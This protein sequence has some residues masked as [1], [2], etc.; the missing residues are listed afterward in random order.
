MYFLAFVV[1]TRYSTRYLE[2]NRET[3]ENPID[4]DNRKETYGFPSQ[5]TPP[6]K[7]GVISPLIKP[8]RE[9]VA[10]LAGSIKYRPQKNS[11]FQKEL[12]KVVSSI[13]RNPNLLISSDK[14][15]NFYE[16]KPG[17]YEK[18]VRDN[19]TT[20]YSKCDDNEP[21][22]EV[23]RED[24]K[25]AKDLKIDDRVFVTQKREA[26][27]FLKDHKQNFRNNPKCRVINPTKQELGKVSKQ[28]L[29]KVQ[30]VSVKVT[31][32]PSMSQGLNLI[33]YW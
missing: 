29:E 2:E 30:G 19:V 18:M 3:N 23:N 31:F 17:D 13:E 1:N 9:A 27:I 15:S 22:N 25:V 20:K 8:F 6:W 21:F 4:E 16:M 11:T 7:N 33:K 26:V 14:T 10:K 32:S 24:R 12:R 5:K 28:I